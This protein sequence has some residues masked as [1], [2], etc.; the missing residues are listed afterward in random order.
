M[1]RLRVAIVGLGMAVGPHAKSLVDLK[2]KAEV[3]WAM[4]PTAARREAFAKNF[5]FPT[6]GDLD[7]VI[8]DKSVDALLVL[9]PP[10]THLE[11][12]QKA[13]AAGKHVLLEKPLDVNTE[14]ATAIVQACDKAGVKLGAVLQHRFR[15]AS[16]RVKQVLA[17]GRLGKIAHA[18]VTVPWW[19]PQKGYYDQPGRGTLARDGGGVLIT[20]A[21]HTLDLLLQY[22]GEPVEA[23][24]FAL[25][26]PL[27]RME[28]E[29]TVVA[30]LRFAGG[31][32]A[33]VEATT[34]APPG[35]PECITLNGTL[36]TATLQAGVLTVVLA[37]G[38]RIE[39]G[40]AQG[41]G[42]ADPMAFDP[43][44]HQSLLHDFVRSIR[45]AREPAVSGRSALAVQ[46]LI[47]TLMRSALG[48]PGAPR[49]RSEGL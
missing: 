24:A 26:S 40:E 25:T 36:G 10:N 30:I 3:A 37:D 38:Q 29:D 23:H 15:P 28:C 45:E 47:D 1:P 44:A 21:I 46:R 49:A 9:T 19:R 34:A 14:R 12:V 20:Q 42:G 35:Y 27:H 4:S 39:V 32:L 8:G 41:G 13:A 17:E 7:Q 6:T 22:T 2:D 5:P 18:S 16:L 33:T 31:A 11:I 43:A 48:A